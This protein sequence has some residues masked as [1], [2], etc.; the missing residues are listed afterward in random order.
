MKT[1]KVRGVLLEVPLL[2][3][4]TLPDKDG[5]GASRSTCTYKVIVLV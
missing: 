5:S 2:I 4:Y 1:E 3:G